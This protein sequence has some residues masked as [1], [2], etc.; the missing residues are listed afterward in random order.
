[1]REEDASADFSGARRGWGGC[2]C[3]GVG[4]AGFAQSLGQVS[5]LLDVPGPTNCTRF[6]PSYNI[7][8]HC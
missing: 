3:G 5:S 2:G 4:C 8:Y 6:F 7:P 1:M